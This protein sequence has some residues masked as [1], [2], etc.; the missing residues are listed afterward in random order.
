MDAK[1]QKWLP[2]FGGLAGT[3]V[4]LAVGIFFIVRPFGLQGTGDPLIPPDQA[5][6]VKV[7][8]YSGQLPQPSMQV[9][10]VNKEASLPEQ[11]RWIMRKIAI[12]YQQE[13]KKE[14]RTLD[15]GIRS[16]YVRKNGLLILDFEKSVQYNQFHG[17][18]EEWQLVRSL[19]RSILENYPELN[20]MKI[21]VGGQEVDTLAGHVDLSRSFILGDIE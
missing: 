14:G 3:A 1:M 20:Q 6:A 13:Y 4:V 7:Y 11:I 17:A 19:V 12:L 2:V 5:R 15:F 16:L 9:V 10:Q 18:W 21:L 8:I